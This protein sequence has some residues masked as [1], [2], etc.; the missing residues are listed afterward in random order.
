MA[1]NG[2]LTAEFLFLSQ[3]FAS[4]L[5]LII[6]EIPAGGFST[7]SPQCSM[8]KRFFL[9]RVDAGHLHT[10]RVCP[11]EPAFI[12]P[13]FLTLQ[14]KGT[15]SAR[16]AF[17][18]HLTRDVITS[19]ES[20]HGRFPASYSQSNLCSTHWPLSLT[21]STRVNS[22]LE[23]WKTSAAHQLLQAEL[24]GALKGPENLPCN[25]CRHD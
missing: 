22:A 24:F 18:L 8:L 3:R 2:D 17:R 9:L 13:S 7:A 4:C 16:P 20:T 6:T 25:C 10:I 11:P 1:L 12:I 21:A 5:P 23:W 19:L 14:P 15:A